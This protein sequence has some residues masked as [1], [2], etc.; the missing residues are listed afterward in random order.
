MFLVSFDSARKTILR[1]TN[2]KEDGASPDEFM[3]FRQSPYRQS[4]IL[5][6]SGKRWSRLDTYLG[7]SYKFGSL[8]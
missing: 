2:R 1:A 7:K 3:I 6:L 4:V 8:S 5:T